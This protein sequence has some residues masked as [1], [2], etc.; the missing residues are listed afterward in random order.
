MKIVRSALTLFFCTAAAVAACAQAGPTASRAADVQLG[1]TFASANSNYT[2]DVYN[3][4]QPVGSDQ[5]K[6]FGAYADIDFRYHFGAEFDYHHV[7][8]SDAILSESTYE[9]GLRYLFPVR[10]FVPYG[11]VMIGR[12]IFNFAAQDANGKSYE[13]ANLGYTTETFGGGLDLK[14][15]PGLHIRAFDYEYQH[16][17]NFPPK[18]LSPQ[19][20]SFGV[21]YHFHGPMSL[22]H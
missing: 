7:T 11:K 15:T 5:W 3:L 21:A 10:R 13:I 1:V 6:G 18:S 2:Q 16:W 8:G 14:L 12:G 17:N 22:R 9:A 4:T 19:V 20:I